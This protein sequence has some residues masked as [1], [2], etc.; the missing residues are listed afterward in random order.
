MKSTSPTKIVVIVLSVLM[1]CCCGGVLGGAALMFRSGSNDYR[2]ARAFAD[3]ALKKT[4]AA[5]DPKVFS[6]Y[7][8]SEWLKKTPPKEFQKIFGRFPERLGPL[9]SV[10]SWSM[11]EYRFRNGKG[12]IRLEGQSTFEKG[13]GVAKVTCI[14]EGSEWKFTSFVISSELLR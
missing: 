10:D 1:F 11:V 7:A 3:H 5:W 6:N 8:S 13:P 14:R 2:E 12:F 9:K 4:G